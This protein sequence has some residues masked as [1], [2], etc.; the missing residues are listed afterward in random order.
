M[1]IDRRHVMLLS[2]LMTYKVG[3]MLFLNVA[4]A[5]LYQ[6]ILPCLRRMGELGTWRSIIGLKNWKLYWSDAADCV[7]NEMLN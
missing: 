3:T 7:S 5:C 6:L 1:S 2:D 4:L